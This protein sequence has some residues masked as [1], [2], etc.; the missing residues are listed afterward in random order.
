MGVWREG[1]AK[2]AAL[3]HV[4]VKLSMLPYM[5]QDWQDDPVREGTVRELILEVISLF[6]V[7]RCMFASNY[8]V[9]KVSG[10][11]FKRMYSAYI[12]W[13]KDFTEEDQRALFHDT[14]ARFYK[15][16]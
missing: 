7:N 13:T 15:L 16:A 11:D 6:G 12:D 1:M 9:D 5:L 8:P 4:C 10:T 2:L 3:P 14:A